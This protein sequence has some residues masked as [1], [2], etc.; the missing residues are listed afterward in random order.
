V[1][2][3]VSYNQYLFQYRWYGVINNSIIALRASTIRVYKWAFMLRWNEELQEKKVGR[4][5]KY[6][7]IANYYIYWPIVG[8]KYI[9]SQESAVGYVISHTLTWCS[10]RKQQE[11]NAQWPPHSISTFLSPGQMWQKQF[12]NLCDG[13]WRKTKGEGNIR[14]LYEYVRDLSPS[15]S[16]Q[17]L[18][19]NKN[20]IIYTTT[21]FYSICVWM[22]SFMLNKEHTQDANTHLSSK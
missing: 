21:R 16:P 8:Y 6:V 18:N 14:F 1:K 17:L 5:L 12:A 19:C 2:E 9:Y 3:H 7:L 4:I 20:L 22:G 11:K 10:T 15:H 13:E